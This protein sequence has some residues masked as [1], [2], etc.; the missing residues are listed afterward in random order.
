MLLRRLP[1]LL[2]AAVGVWMWKG[3]GGYFPSPREI[4]WELGPNRAGIRE[5]EIQLADEKGALVKRDQ[6]FF[7]EA[8]PAEV[9]EKVRLSEGSYPARV[10]IKREPDRPEEQF[11][12][13]V[14]VG[15]SE[16]VVV[17]LGEERN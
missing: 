3:G 6:F 4:L 17:W 11:S 7:H 14:I 10:F 2:V 13:T 5:V 16:T 9:A 1:I 8:P 12:R 15:E